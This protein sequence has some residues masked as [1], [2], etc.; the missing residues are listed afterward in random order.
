MSDAVR[1]KSQSEPSRRGAGRVP[2]SHREGDGSDAGAVPAWQAALGDPAPLLPRPPAPQPP[3]APDPSET[4]NTPTADEARAGSNGVEGRGAAVPPSVREVLS[5]PGDTLDARTRETMESKLGHDLG[6]VRVHTDARASES[7]RSL[8]APAY[9]FGQDI[10][11]GLGQ[12]RPGTREGDRLLAHELT[13]A[14][15]S[16]EAAAGADPAAASVAPHDHVA[17]R[18]AERAEDSHDA[19]AHMFRPSPA[20]LAIYR[21][22]PARGV[23]APAQPGDAGGATAAAPPQP[24]EFVRA[25]RARGLPVG[26]AQNELLRY[27]RGEAAAE[28]NIDGGRWEGVRDAL[29]SMSRP[30]A[31]EGGAGG[32]AASPQPTGGAQ[33]SSANAPAAG[34]GGPA[35]GAARPATDER[36]WAVGVL[37]FEHLLPAAQRRDLRER[38]E[39]ATAAQRTA[40]H[41]LIESLWNRYV[42]LAHQRALLD[43]IQTQIQQ[44]R[45][46]RSTPAGARRLAALQ[47]WALEVQERY[48]TGVGDAPPQQQG[49]QQQGTQQPQPAAGAQP[50]AS[51]QPAAGTQPNA[52]AQPPAAQAPVAQ[53][54]AAPHRLRPPHIPFGG[55]RAALERL[56]EASEPVGDINGDFLRDETRRIYGQIGAPMRYQL[57]MELLTAGWRR[58]AGAA[59]DALRPEIERLRGAVAAAQQTLASARAAATGPRDPSVRRAEARA[60]DAQRRLD[61]ALRQRSAQMDILTAPLRRARPDLTAEHVFDDESLTGAGAA[62]YRVETL[63]SLRA[64]RDRQLGQHLAAPGAGGGFDERLAAALGPGGDAEAARHQIYL[65]AANN[66]EHGFDGNY[67]ES[68]IAPLVEAMQRLRRPEQP[69]TPGSARRGPRLRDLGIESDRAAGF[70]SRG[71]HGLGAF[72]IEAPMEEAPGPAVAG[73]PPQARVPV[74][75]T[76]RFPRTITLPEAFPPSY[77]HRDTEFDHRESF[78]IF[79]GEVEEAAEVNYRLRG[80]VTFRRVGRGLRTRESEI[81]LLA[82]MTNFDA[83]HL[84]QEFRSHREAAR[85]QVEAAVRERLREQGIEVGAGAAGQSTLREIGTRDFFN[86]MANPLFTAHLG[87]RAGAGSPAVPLSPRAARAAVMDAARHAL[88]NM[89]NAQHFQA[90]ADAMH[91]DNIPMSGPAGRSVQ[92]AHRYVQRDT[93]LTRFVVVN[94]SHLASIPSTLRQNDAA[95]EGTVVGTVG[96]TGNAIDPHVHLSLQVREARHGRPHNVLSLT[97]FDFF[98]ELSRL[99]TPPAR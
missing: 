17:E 96:M 46:R 19:G 69:G 97:P 90:M 26:E 72:D 93:G 84:T 62:E 55:V 61:A 33:G 28:G 2:E 59:A 99:R 54:P 30:P 25:L 12:Y 52:G 42:S 35:R 98:P 20:P 41:D 32:N 70:M 65:G 95:P 37:R 51:A 8:D 87:R 92:V 9:T 13:H 11:F 4:G 1:A 21:Q 49:A 10:V 14:V 73:Q 86:S 39:R 60:G 15:Q 75:V 83:S 34:R 82:L 66:L 36:A 22:R 91:H 78:V 81:A 80:V 94:Y 31:A 88:V 89:R 58:R 24:A 40:A 5:S 76:V 53:T 67:H 48:E 63:A 18:E 50:A 45:R 79:V 74:Q 44:L 64:E 6:A 47:E 23:N 56:T 38:V 43:W 3:S 77:E 85:E 16:S 29:V 57:H 68:L 71:G 27:L 7:A